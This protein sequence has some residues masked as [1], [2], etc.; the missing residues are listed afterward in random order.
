MFQWVVGNTNWAWCTF[1]LGWLVQVWNSVPG[2]PAGIRESP[3]APRRPPLRTPPDQ[4]EG[5]RRVWLRRKN[6]RSLSCPSR[7]W[8]RL[9]CLHW[10]KYHPPA[11]PPPGRTRYLSGLSER[12]WPSGAPRFAV[13]PWERL[14][15]LPRSFPPTHNIYRAVSIPC[16]HFDKS[17]AVS[18][19]V[20]NLLEFLTFHFIRK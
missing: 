16:S 8:A 10:R 5:E 17:E 11:S 14:N 6:G 20:K 1:I 4:D 15:P 9:F 19:L 12:D 13:A 7:V 2:R 3:S 18:V